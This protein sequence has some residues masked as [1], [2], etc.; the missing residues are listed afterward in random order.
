MAEEMAWQSMQSPN[1]QGQVKDATPFIMGATFLPKLYILLA[2][3]DC[4][5]GSAS[6]KQT[7]LL[8]LLTT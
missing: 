4:A 5:L 7:P 3:H 1:A 2:R 8:S 6:H